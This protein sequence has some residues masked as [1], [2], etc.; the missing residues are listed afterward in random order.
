MKETHSTGKWQGRNVGL[1]GRHQG[2]VRFP[3]W[4]KIVHLGIWWLSF[5]TPGMGRG[6]FWIVS[7]ICSLLS[8]LKRPDPC[9]PRGQLVAAHRLKEAA[10]RKPQNR[11]GRGQR[12]DP[13]PG[14]Q[15]CSWGP[16]GDQGRG[17]WSQLICSCCPASDYLCPFSD[18]AVAAVV[19]GR[20]GVEAAHWRP[21]SIKHSN[22]A[23]SK[24]VSHLKPITDEANMTSS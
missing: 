18:T 9:S 11:R 2:S 7:G 23:W 6:W 21:N 8:V 15:S 10:L 20:E 19:T 1:M 22:V 17:A 14:A 24:F 16:S 12:A 4:W 5:A 3:R 13:D